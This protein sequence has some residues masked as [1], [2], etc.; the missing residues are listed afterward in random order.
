MMHRQEDVSIQAAD[1]RKNS[2]QEVFTRFLED[3]CDT[4][5]TQEDIALLEEVLRELNL[6]E[7]GGGK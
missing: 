1:A 4:E 2:H 3:V 6:Q 5:V 7:R